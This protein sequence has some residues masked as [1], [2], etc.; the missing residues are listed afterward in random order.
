MLSASGALKQGQLKHIQPILFE[1]F[2]PFLTFILGSQFILLH[3]ANNQKGSSL[4]SRIGQDRRFF[5]Y[6]LDFSMPGAFKLDCL[7]PVRPKV[8]GIMSGLSSGTRNVSHLKEYL[9]E[10]L[11]FLIRWL[12]KA[13]T[14]C[15]ELGLNP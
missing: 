15:P 1:K 9:G 5:L 4:N 11:S 14:D 10:S 3:W 8:S 2:P 7:Q 12:L 6:S 13:K